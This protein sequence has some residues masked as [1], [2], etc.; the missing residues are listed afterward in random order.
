MDR[1]S[2]KVISFS[3]VILLMFFNTA[4]SEPT[5]RDTVISYYSI[6]CVAFNPYVDTQTYVRGHPCLYST[7]LVGEN[8][9]L[10]PVFLPHDAEVIEFKAWVYDIDNTYNVYVNI[11]RDSLASY[12]PGEVMA[13]C[14][15]SVSNGFE[16]LTDNTISFPIIDNAT[17]RYWA[18]V[19]FPSGNVSLRLLGM[20]IEYQ[21]TTTAVQESQSI[22]SPI[23]R[24]NI[25]AYPVPFFM[26]TAINYTVPKRE[27]V[28]I[29][30]YDDAGRLVR[31]LVN[32]VLDVGFYTA[33]WDGRDLGG[34]IVPAGS[35]F[36]IVKTNGKETSKLI[37]VE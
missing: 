13:S 21:V 26:N 30:I 19:S 9:F 2:V 25:E 12:G 7:S 20:R 17:Y 35:Y 23:N 32:S 33:R 1:I 15:S 22:V 16:E 14:V 3:S 34:R 24:S 18:G 6:P 8:V 11:G 28:S 5:M 29:K 37:R 10:A 27:L 36:C 4:F 31:M